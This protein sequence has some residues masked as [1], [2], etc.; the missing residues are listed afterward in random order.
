M[1]S[2][3]TVANY[4]PEVRD[5][6]VR[7]VLDGAVVGTPLVPGISTAVPVTTPAEAGSQATSR[8]RH[9]RT[10]NAVLPAVRR[11]RGDGNNDMRGRLRGERLGTTTRPLHP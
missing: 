6:A 1:T 3:K 9:S 2:R 7:M 5:R 10:V 4:S 11:W 8:P